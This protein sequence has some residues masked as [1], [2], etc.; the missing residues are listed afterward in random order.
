MRCGHTAKDFLGELTIHKP[1]RSLRLNIGTGV[2]GTGS[3]EVQKG[4][5]TNAKYTKSKEVEK[6]G[7]D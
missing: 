5:T 1:L 7:F 3:G 2:I 4:Q 6:K